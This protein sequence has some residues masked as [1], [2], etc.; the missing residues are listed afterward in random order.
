MLFNMEA[1]IINMCFH[2]NNNEMQTI[3]LNRAVP[4]QSA[5]SLPLLPSPWN[6]IKDPVVRGPALITSLCYLISKVRWVCQLKP[7]IEW[8][9]V[10]LTNKREC[11]PLSHDPHWDDADHVRPPAKISYFESFYV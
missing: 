10:I 1:I 3:T 4:V 7:P 8:E 5:S 6:D 9:G 2:A 11:I